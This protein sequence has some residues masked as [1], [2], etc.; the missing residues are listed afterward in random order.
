[1]LAGTPMALSRE[2]V[3]TLALLLVIDRTSTPGISRTICL[4]QFAML[5]TPTLDFEYHYNTS[6][7]I[8]SRKQAPDLQLKIAESANEADLKLHETDLKLTEADLQ[9]TRA[10]SAKSIK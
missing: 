1:M 7:T 5:F 9:L 10:D 8:V 4:S 2:T 6:S 3:V